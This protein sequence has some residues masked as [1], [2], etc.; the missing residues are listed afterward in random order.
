MRKI[1]IISLLSSLVFVSCTK[2]DFKKVTVIKDCTGSYLRIDNKEYFVCNP[3]KINNVESGKEIEVNYKFSSQCDDGL[4]RCAMV[5]EN[6]G[7]VK[8]EKVK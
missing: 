6:N 1:L 8:I 5:H 3:E 4:I 7:R 2:T